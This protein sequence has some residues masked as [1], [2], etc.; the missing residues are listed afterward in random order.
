MSKKYVMIFQHIPIISDGILE[1]HRRFLNKQ[2]DISEP[3][4]L[5]TEN[6]VS[7]SD[8]GKGELIS[9][10]KLRKFLGK[11]ISGEVSYCL[12]KDH[13]L[14]NNSSRDDRL[15]YEFNPEKVDYKALVNDVFPELVRSF[16]CYRAAI[17]DED[18]FLPHWRELKRVN[19]EF[20]KD[21]N[22]RDG[23]FYINPVTYFSRSLCNLEFSISPDEIVSI[24]DGKIEHVSLLLDGVLIRYSSEVLSETEYDAVDKYIRSLLTESY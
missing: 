10:T 21:L 9:I 7:V 2:A 11:G 12:R 19:R 13:Y 1:R 5:P 16:E 6:S 22:G 24:L 23:V 3:W 4:R 8:I 14:I 18:A 17:Y 20:G 15:I